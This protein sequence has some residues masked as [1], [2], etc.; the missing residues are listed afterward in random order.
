MSTRFLFDFSVNKANN[1]ILV[2]REFA[3]D[4]DLVWEAW[5]NPELL[6]L[7]WAPKPYRTQTKNMDFSEGGYWHYCMISPENEVHWCRADYQKVEPKKSFSGL[8][9]FCDENGTVVQDFPRSLWNNVFAENA[10]KTTLVEITISY[11][12]LS[13]L[14][15]VVEM[16]FKEGFSMAL[17]NL[18]Q[19]LETQCQ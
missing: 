2:K 18:D 4:L 15:K 10:N 13:D 14:E 9:A 11:D 3:A 7:W 1:T 17:E 6:D 12:S 8:D 5:T 16:G 19:Y